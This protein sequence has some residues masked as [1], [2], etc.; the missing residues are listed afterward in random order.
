MGAIAQPPRIRR[1]MTSRPQVVRQS[2]KITFGPDQHEASEVLRA[3]GRNLASLRAE[4]S[5]SQQKL[6]DRCF[7]HHDQISSF[8]RGTRRPNLLALLLLAHALDV[9]MDRLTED[10]VAPARWASVGQMLELLARRPGITTDDAVESLHLPSW[11]VRELVLYLESV[12]AIVRERKG[13]ESGLWLA[14]VGPTE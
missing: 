7:M 3:F 4:A 14:S 13:L 5:L 2:R 1:A 12:G 11:Y 6:A 10:L 9:S 8:E